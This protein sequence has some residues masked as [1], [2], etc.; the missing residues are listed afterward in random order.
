MDQ[1]EDDDMEEAADKEID[2]VLWEL[3]KGK[4]T[5]FATLSL[6]TGQ[7]GYQ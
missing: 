3:T 4:R 1:M 7:L 5:S 6:A 2:N